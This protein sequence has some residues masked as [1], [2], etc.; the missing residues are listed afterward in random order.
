M[1]SAS[2]SAVA[3]IG[4]ALSVP[5]HRIP[6][7]DG[8][9][10]HSTLDWVGHLLLGGD[11]IDRWQIRPCARPSCGRPATRCSTGSCFSS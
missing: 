6:A 8:T 10:A 7:Y 1:Y 3:G 11:A 4:E 2:K 9:P 5:E